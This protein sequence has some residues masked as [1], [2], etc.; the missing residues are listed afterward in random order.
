MVWDVPVKSKILPVNSVSNIVTR[1][2]Q[3]W[4]DGF[5]HSDK[6]FQVTFLKHTVHILM[7]WV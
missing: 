6:L 7:L 5:P 1:V 2:P 3:P 4:K